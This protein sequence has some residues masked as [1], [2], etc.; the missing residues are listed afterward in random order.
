MSSAPAWIDKRALLLLH[1]ES[2]AQFGGADGLRDEGLLDSALARPV[3]KHAY[4]GC[5]DLS[6]LAA[7]YGFGLIRN[8]PFVDGNKRAAFLA[9]GVFLAI[10]GRR[11]TATPVE[12]IEAILALAAGS[13]DEAGFAQWVRGNSAPR[14]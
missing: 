13:L 3:N 14:A 7:A 2:L 9:V 11:L 5:T 10:N 8:H 1:R 4:E 12:A 6:A